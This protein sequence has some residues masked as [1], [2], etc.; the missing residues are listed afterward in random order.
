M[1]SSI[2]EVFLAQHA[3]VRAAPTPRAPSVEDRFVAGLTEAQLRQ[4]LEHHDS[5]VWLLWM[6]H[7]LFLSWA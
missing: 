4:C 7:P 3:N 6:R 2:P 1:D 5:I